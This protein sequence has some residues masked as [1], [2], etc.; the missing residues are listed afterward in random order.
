MNGTMLFKVHVVSVE[1]YIFNRYMNS[2]MYKT[3]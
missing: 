1:R 3:M 2:T